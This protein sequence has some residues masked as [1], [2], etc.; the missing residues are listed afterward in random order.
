MNLSNYNKFWVALTGA[1][2][3][4]VTLTA[5]CTDPR[6]HVAIG[7]LTALGVVVTP[8]VNK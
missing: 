3:Q 8:N 7:I 2:G 5:G 1:A 4:L 6:V